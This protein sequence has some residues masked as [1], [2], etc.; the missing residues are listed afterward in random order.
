MS[1]VPQPVHRIARRLLLVVGLMAAGVA[2]LLGTAGGA[3]AATTA[4]TTHLSPLNTGYLELDVSGASTQPGAPVIDWWA[5]GGANQAWT[6]QPTGSPDQYEIVNQNSGQCLTTSGV[7]GA[8][9][10]QWP[11]SPNDPY[12]VWQTGLG[13]YYDGHGYGIRN[14]AFNLYVDVYG[15]SPWPGAAIDAWY[16]NN[17]DNQ[18]FRSI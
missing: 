4:F 12:Q 18:F 14:P 16:G 17:G 9:L 11:C 1:L 7:A 3:S 5:N 6:L 13:A 15:D 8:Q 10:Y 2:V